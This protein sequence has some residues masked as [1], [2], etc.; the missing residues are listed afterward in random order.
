MLVG[1]ARAQ[2]KGA[3]PD[4]ALRSYLSG[5]GFLTRGMYELAAKEYRDFLKEHPDHTKAAT[6]RYGLGVALVRMKQYDQAAEALT[7]LAEVQGFEFAAEAALLLAQCDLA[8]GKLDEAAAGLE[9]LKN[10]AV[11]DDAGVMLAEA[12]YRAGQYDQ[13]EAACRDLL[14]RKPD[15]ALRDRLEL[16]WGMA[17][18]ARGDAAHAAERF[19]AVAGRAPDSQLGRQAVLLRGQCLQ[20][21]GDLDGATEAYEKAAG[22]AASPFAPDAAVGLASLRRQQGR[23][24]E[25]GQMLDRVIKEHPDSGATGAA[26]MERGRVWLDLNKQ[27]RARQLFT[28]AAKQEG[29]APDEVEY[30]LA[31][32]DLRAGDA[33]AAAARLKAASAK[34]P[35]SRLTPEMTYDRGVALLRAGKDADAAKVLAAFREKFPDHTLAADALEATATI[36]HRAG[37]YEQSLALC[38]DFAKAYPKHALATRVEFLRAENLCQAGKQDEAIEAFGAFARAHP[39]DASAGRA[40]LRLGTLLFGQGKYDHARP[41]L[42]RVAPLAEKDAT[43][44]PAVLC[45]GDLHFQKSEWDEARRWL[46]TYAEFGDNAPS[47]DDAALKEGLALE[48]LGKH[49]EAIAQFARVID[50]FPK[51]EHR[52]QAEFEGAQALLAMGRSD[53]ARAGF[54][55]VLKDGQGTPFAAYSLTQLGSMTLQSG[56]ASAAAERF[57][58]AAAMAADPATKGEAMFQRGQAL[59]SAG[60]YADAAEAFGG[61][62]HDLPSHP[63]IAAAAAQRAIALARTKRDESALKAIEEASR[64]SSLDEPTKNTLAYERAC[65]LKEL[66]KREEA[67]QV[68]RGLA[69]STSAVAPYAMLDLAAAESEAGRLDAAVELLTKVRASGGDSARELQ[70]QATY[71]L[72][73]CRFK[74]D[75]PKES[76]ALLEEYFKGEPKG[77]L[78]APA[79]LLA[80]ECRLKL[81]RGDEAAADFRRILQEFKGD[82]AAPTAALRLGDALAAAQDWAGSER[83]FADY[84]RDHPGSELWF[85]AQFGLG[86]ARENQGRQAE[87]IEAYR[88]VTEK[89]NGPTAARAQFQIG[90]CLFAQ[91]KYEDAAAELLKVDI[92]YAYPEWSAPALYESGRCL[93]SLGK[94]E[95]AAEQFKQVRSK[96]PESKWSQLAASRLTGADT[97]H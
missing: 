51:S 64:D 32:C 7:P 36:E 91:K 1:G 84:L 34:Y 93:E 56:D 45:L 52:V 88:R 22:D 19:A 8:R 24:E 17:A 89:H 62:I 33:A 74:Q 79:T 28:E 73:V 30:W 60:R 41:L 18:M 2:D 77:E 3:E 44:R 92:L 87:A 82:P 69:N 47:A 54:K 70:E 95:Q 71:R 10:T 72:A 76:L 94:A 21:A 20:R 29:V 46:S 43:F 63:R 97:R 50:R 53:E 14:A 59:M 37:R 58:S 48:R 12:R 27:D 61:L 80:G 78:V 31:K 42:E 15:T 11:A 38:E 40:T 35:E 5:N 26:M 23:A 16:L 67:E 90:E 4:P 85:Q 39:D 86:W 6:A 96:Y 66:G 57:E 25:A 13:A 68:L 81:G 65:C 9:R 75:N 83:A 49:D 55:R